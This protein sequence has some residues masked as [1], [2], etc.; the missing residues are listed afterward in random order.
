MDN[1]PVPPEITDDKLRIRIE[2]GLFR[3]E[4]ECRSGVLKY[5]P[6][7]LQ[8]VFDVYADEL[9]QAEQLTDARLESDIP[10]W[11]GNWA[12][13]RGLRILQPLP[14]TRRE[15]VDYYCVTVGSR[16]MASLRNQ[17]AEVSPTARLA[18]ICQIVRPRVLYWRAELLSP[19]G[20]ITERAGEVAEDKTEDALPAAKI[21]KQKEVQKWIA[22]IQNQHPDWD[23]R[24]DIT[25][26]VRRPNGSRISYSS[27]NRCL[28]HPLEATLTMLDDIA[29]GLKTL[30]SE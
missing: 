23:L 7:R 9:F 20:R 4:S 6:P 28:N 21:R 24:S 18:I 3:V 1:S 10:R 19:E 25:K 27:L 15:P 26:R 2:A 17:T 5:W 11:V 16:L 29:A 22:K 14:G 30:S 13:L 12:W 8:R